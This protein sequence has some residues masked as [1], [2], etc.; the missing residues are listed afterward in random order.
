MKIKKLCALK[1]TDLE[2]RPKKLLKIVE[3]PKY[4]CEKCARVAK[5]K[6]HLCKAVALKK[7]VKSN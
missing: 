3:K 5:E 1:K 4:I 6:T 7:W 2:Q